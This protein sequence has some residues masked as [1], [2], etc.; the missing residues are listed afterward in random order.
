MP[1]NPLRKIASLKNTAKQYHCAKPQAPEGQK[2]FT[3]GRFGFDHE[4]TFSNLTIS[5]TTDGSLHQYKRSYKHGEKT[6]EATFSAAKGA[7]LIHPVEP[8]HKP[9][10]ITDFLE[11]KFKPVI[12][13]PESKCTIYLTFPVEIACM[14]E[15]ASGKAE[16]LDVVTAVS[17]KF[18]MYG[19]S[20]RGVITRYHESEVFYTIP[21]VK[22]YKHGVLRLHIKNDTDEWATIGRAVFYMKGL[23]IYFDKDFAAACAQMDITSKEVAKT[24]FENGIL[25]DGMEEAE[26]LFEERKTDSFM[27]TPATLLVDETFTMDMGLI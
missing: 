26:S 8:N 18:S 15:S 23:W 13:E 20:A 22:N 4:V 11:I 17:P 16:I 5:V 9:S 25:C 1:V 6:R 14:L 24:W 27:N 19:T 10:S 3:F 21:Q 2:H 12:I 7:L